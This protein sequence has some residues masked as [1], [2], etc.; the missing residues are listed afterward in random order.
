MCFSKSV[1]ASRDN[2]LFLQLFQT[3]SVQLVSHCICALVACCI[4]SISKQHFAAASI[5][6]FTKCTWKS[7]R[8]LTVNF[9]VCSAES[10]A[11]LSLQDKFF[12]QIN[13]HIQSTAQWYSQFKQATYVILKFCVTID[14]VE[15][16]D[17]IFFFATEDFKQ[18]L[19]FTH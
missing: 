6:R 10:E 13:S 3:E 14:L 18:L 9:F 1:S 19:D 16:F 2:E 15:I 11:H 17:R 4:H 8:M 7:H 12:I 5:W